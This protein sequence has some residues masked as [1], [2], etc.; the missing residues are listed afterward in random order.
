MSEYTNYLRSLIVEDSSD[1][2]DEH[3]LNVEENTELW[4]KKAQKRK[5]TSSQNSNKRSKTTR[6]QKEQTDQKNVDGTT[7]DDPLEGPSWRYT[8]DNDQAKSSPPGPN[9]RYEKNYGRIAK[10]Q[11]ET[12]YSGEGQGQISER[13]YE[14]GTL[15]YRDMNVD[16][17]VKA[18]DHKRNTRFRSDDHLYEINIHPKRRNAPLLLSLETALREA[19]LAILMTLKGNYSTDLHHQVYVT[20]IEKNILHGLNTGNFDLN[21]PSHEI[22]NRAL[23]IL[24]SYLKSNQT[25]KLND[26]FKIQIRVLGHRHTEHLLR[27]NPRFTKKMF[28]TYG[29]IR[30]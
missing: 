14:K 28:Y 4:P 11:K 18:V 20:I 7:V 5:S 1:S 17:E 8:A 10:S 21:G 27:H 15:V 29:K 23:T 9:W 16:V 2:N 13:S 30:N 3:I 26:S 22:V 12:Q 6:A 19:L 24:H 25:M